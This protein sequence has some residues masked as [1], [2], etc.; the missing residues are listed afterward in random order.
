MHLELSHE[1]EARALS[2]LSL[3][4]LQNKIVA[5]GKSG[6]AYPLKQHRRNISANKQWSP[7][8]KLA[9]PLLALPVKFPKSWAK[10][11]L[12]YAKIER[13]KVLLVQNKF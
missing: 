4:T 10:I 8:K 11:I 9:Y 12:R 13:K 6:I 5:E 3:S 7:P 2:T 1:E